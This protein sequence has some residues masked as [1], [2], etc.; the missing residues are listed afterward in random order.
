[1]TQPSYSTALYVITTLAQIRNTLNQH[2]FQS[3]QFTVPLSLHLT[4]S[5][6]WFFFSV[7]PR[8]L[9]YYLLPNFH[10]LT[11]YKL[12][13]PSEHFINHFHPWYFPA[14][15]VAS[16]HFRQS[17]ILGG[18]GVRTTH[19]PSVLL[20]VKGWNT[21]SFI[22]GS[23]QT[24][25]VDKSTVWCFWPRYIIPFRGTYDLACSI[26]RPEHCVTKYVPIYLSRGQESLKLSVRAL[27][28]NGESAVNR[29]FDLCLQVFWDR[30]WCCLE[31]AHVFINLFFKWSC[32]TVCPDRWTEDKA[33]LVAWPSSKSSV[34]SPYATRRGSCYMMCG[35]LHSFLVERWHWTVKDGERALGAKYRGL[36]TPQNQPIYSIKMCYLISYAPGCAYL[37]EIQI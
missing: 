7:W 33:M 6:S 22:L 24:T 5:S 19:L 12:H 31:G 16:L 37:E 3:P 4:S 23:S 13:F 18:G 9:S 28:S 21:D 20:K 2:L 10:S 34:C 25:A 30:H 35:S 29:W 11:C 36:R 17:D 32:C 1:M 14:C 26:W 27:L 8:I 15:Q